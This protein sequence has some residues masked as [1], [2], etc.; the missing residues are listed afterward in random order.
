M[1]EELSHKVLA[2]ISF[3]FR[4]FFAKMRKGDHTLSHVKDVGCGQNINCQS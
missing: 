2:L 1:S 3:T 4:H